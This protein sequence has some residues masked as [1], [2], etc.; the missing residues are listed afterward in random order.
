MKWFVTL[1]LA[2]LLAFAA[3]PAAAQEDDEDA[4]TYDFDDDLVTGDLVRPDGEMLS[5]RRRGRRSSLIQIREHF[6]PE[7]LKSVEDL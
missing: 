4:T 1:A 6:I 7:M 3:A 5:V 2:G